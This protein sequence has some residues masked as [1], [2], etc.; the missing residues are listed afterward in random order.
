[1][2]AGV[3]GVDVGV[4]G[5]GGRRAVLESLLAVEPETAPVVRIDVWLFV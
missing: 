2:D 5:D 4:A 1:V 3:D